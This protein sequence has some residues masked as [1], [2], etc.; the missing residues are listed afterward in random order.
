MLD[1]RFKAIPSLKE[2]IVN[3]HVYGD[4][5][6]SDDLSDEEDARLRMDR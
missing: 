3:I 2:I 5:D 4:E 1:T 6:L